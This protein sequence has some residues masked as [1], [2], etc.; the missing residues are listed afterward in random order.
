MKTII[1]IMLAAVLLQGTSCS[2]EQAIEKFAVDEMLP[3][4]E[5]FAVTTTFPTGAEMN[6]RLG[7]GINLGG[8]YEGQVGWYNTDPDT[9][10]HYIDEIVDRGFHHIRLPVNWE[11]PDR[12]DP[13]APP[14]PYQIKWAFMSQVKATV[15]YAMSK[16]LRV[17]LNMHNHDALM[18]NP[19]ANKAMFLAQWEHISWAFRDYSTDSLLFE[20]LNEPYQ[21]MTPAKWNTFLLD[22]LAAIRSMGGNSQERCVL[23]GVANQGGPDALRLL[24]FPN[25]DPYTI[26]TIHMYYPFWFTH[27]SATQYTGTVWD[28]TDFERNVIRGWMDYIDLYA[29]F[30][31]IPVHIG[32]FG[33]SRDADAAGD[34]VKYTEFLAKL[35]TQHGYSWTYFNYHYK[36][37]I[38]N[39]DTQQYNWSLI[40]ALYNSNYPMPAA[41]VPAH[42][43]VVYQ[44][45]ITDTN[46]D[47]WG[48]WTHANA[49][50][51]MDAQSGNKIEV[52]ITDPGDELWHVQL[53]RWGLPIVAGR[54]YAV[55]FKASA[56][57]LWYKIQARFEAP[58]NTTR[59]E[60]HLFYTNGFGT[61]NMVFTADTTSSN[62][63]LLF[64]LGANGSPNTQKVTIGD[65]K[66]TEFYD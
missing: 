49:S 12:M 53:L 26:L 8:A 29:M 46:S 32:E 27:Q 9:I 6:E 14:Q 35:F 55:S 13:T 4:S 19:D 30:R 64:S 52:T 44:S 16:G 51:T 1:I 41:H 24:N 50:A 57:T 45:N 2:R 20:I 21:N 33:A 43:S 54:R 3:V 7:L 23:I 18:A 39:Q 66:M 59:G 47:S 15:D 56:T 61:Y 5:T 28:D 38:Y 40:G 36:W 31:N 11:R 17:I 65:I 58:Q 42:S 48:I 10:R 62:G 22:G 25:N 63:G 60:G 37:G 34:R